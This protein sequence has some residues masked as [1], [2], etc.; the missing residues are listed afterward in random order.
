MEKGE[1]KA[2]NIAEISREMEGKSAL[3]AGAGASAFKRSVAIFDL[4]LRISAAVAALAA[5]ITMGTTEQTLPFFTQF[6]QFTA[7]YEDLPA[8]TFFVIALSISTGYLVLSV[9]FSVVCVVQPLHTGPRLLLIFCDTLTLI[10]AT[11]AAASSAAIV[12]LAHNGNS[13]ANW[14]PLCQQFG[15][16]CQR[17]SGAVVAGFIA[18][19]L[20]LI[21]MVLSALALRNH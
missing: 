16:F 19:A 15:D 13:D 4:I 7:S 20:L 6:F 11:S 1:A 2:I 5:T 3:L 10:L 18:V 9:P 17:I 14:L 12:Y 21:M 8:F